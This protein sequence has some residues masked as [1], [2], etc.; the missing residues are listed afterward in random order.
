MSGR[1]ATVVAILSVILA[2]CGAGMEPTPPRPVSPPPSH[3]PSSLATVIPAPTA[4]VPSP[5]PAAAATTTPSPTPDDPA[6]PPASPT[7]TPAAEP[8]GPTRPLDS[9]GPGYWM[10]V[11]SDNLRV[12]SKPGTGEDSRKYEP[13]LHKGACFLIVKG[14][15]AA[16]GYVWYLV[17]L[18]FP[19]S[20]LAGGVTRGWV[21][22]GDRDGTWWIDNSAID[23][24]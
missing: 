4:V 10:C 5:T 9:Y 13:L 17:D 18:A 20:P 14:P 21:A 11:I 6:S 22:A 3:G 19:D 12:R 23:Q 16:S 1:Q 8:G 2:G 7:P 15:V 24:G